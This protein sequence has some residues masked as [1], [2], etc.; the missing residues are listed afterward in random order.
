M[1]EM[2]V[3]VGKMEVRVGYVEV[4]V[5]EELLRHGA[6]LGPQSVSEV[7]SLRGPGSVHVHVRLREM[8]VVRHGRVRRVHDDLAVYQRCQICSLTSASPIRVEGGRVVI[9]VQ[10]SVFDFLESAPAPLILAGVVGR[11]FN[12]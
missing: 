7:A 1:G 12:H 4:R 2:E 10:D 9:H 11:C 6:F 3:R 8:P 5:G